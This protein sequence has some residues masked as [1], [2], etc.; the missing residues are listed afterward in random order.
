MN[1]KYKYSTAG[2]TPYSG[3]PHGVD[4]VW[5]CT[6]CGA[7]KARGP[8]NTHTGQ[9]VIRWEY[10]DTSGDPVSSMPACYGSM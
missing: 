3:R 2:V 6:R 4:E 10:T 1:H 8:E 5:T 7:S 9:R